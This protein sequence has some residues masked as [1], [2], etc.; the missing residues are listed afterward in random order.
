M[1]GALVFAQI[2]STAVRFKAYSACSAMRPYA[3]L[4]SRQDMRAFVSLHCCF[5]REGSM[6]YV[7][8]YFFF[9]RFHVYTFV[10]YQSYV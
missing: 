1:T 10:S 5:C 2:T 9:L 3:K 8:I 7:A 4:T 6:A